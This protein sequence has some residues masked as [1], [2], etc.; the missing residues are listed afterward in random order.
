[1]VLLDRA[2]EREAIDEAIK[3]VESGHSRVFVLAGEAGMGKTSLLNHAVDSASQLQTA[4]I[5]GVEAEGDLGFAALHRLMRP[6]MPRLD[7]LPE[8]QRRALKAAFGLTT[9]TPADRFLVGLA[10]LNLLADFGSDRGLLC[11][12]DDAQWIDR[13]SLEALSFVAR[14]LDADRVALLFGI[15]DLSHVEGA[16]DGLTILHIDGL[17]D[18]AALEL[19]TASVETPIEPDTARRIIGETGGCPLAL[20]ELATGLTQQQLRG[21]EPLAD[22]MPIGRQ[23]ED[24]FLKAVR[25]LSASAQT[26][27]LVAAAETSGDLA[28]VRRAAFELGADAEAEDTAIA[29]GLVTV[30]PGVSF[31]HPLIRA[32]VHSGATG[33]QHAIWFTKRSPGS[34]TE[35]TPIVECNTLP[36]QPEGLMRLSLSTWNKRRNDPHVAV[37]TPLKRNFCSRQPNCLQEATTEGGDFCKLL[38]RRGTLAFRCAHKLFLSKLAPF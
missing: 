27:L 35:R 19:L 23:L 20:V 15:R 10:C 6:L 28:L 11:V 21:G 22:V 31:R 30:Q 26:F 9:S 36:R 17:P 32:A 12:I 18:E 13:E 33:A 38:L 7:Q 4:W 25:S 8:P 16:F 5:A 3:A 24:H 34:S 1:M 37:V 29:S 2:E 14:R